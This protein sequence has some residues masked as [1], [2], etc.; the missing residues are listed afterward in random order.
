MLSVFPAFQNI[1]V[2]AVKLFYPAEFRC[3]DY[4]FEDSCLGTP[5]CKDTGGY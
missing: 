4:A 2:H 5:K 3:T 1:G